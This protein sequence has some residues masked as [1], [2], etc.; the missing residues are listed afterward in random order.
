MPRL[1]PAASST[2]SLQDAGG[3]KPKTDEKPKQAEQKAA[4]PKAATH[5]HVRSLKPAVSSHGL[6]IRS[7]RP[8]IG[9]WRSRGCRERKASA[10]P[11]GINIHV[12]TQLHCLPADKQ[13]SID[14]LLEFC[15]NNV[16]SSFSAWISG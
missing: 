5:P 4:A 8:S 7:K 15:G 16:R 14:T 9:S 2:R 13:F 1:L 3:D 11:C 10:P 6:S 12:L